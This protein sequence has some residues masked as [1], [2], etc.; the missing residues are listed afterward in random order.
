MSDILP[1]KTDAENESAEPLFIELTDD[2]ADE[3]FNALSSNTSREI[4][5]YLHKDPAPPSELAEATEI[6]LQTT[7]YHLEKLESANL[8]EPIDTWY[9]SRGKEMTVYAPTN[10]PLVIMTGSENRKNF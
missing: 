4:L 1:F 9:S 2:A 3:I 7:R 8:I 5:T 6:T 10:D